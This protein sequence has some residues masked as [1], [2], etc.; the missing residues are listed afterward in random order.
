MQRAFALI[1]R[2][3]LN[4][5]GNLEPNDLFRQITPISTWAGRRCRGKKTVVVAYGRSESQATSNAIQLAHRITEE[6]ICRKMLA[7]EQDSSLAVFKY[8]NA[9]LILENLKKKW[10][11]SP[12]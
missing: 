12:K 1:K 4:F 7:V 5:A 9:L 11:F 3:G 8:F 10:G 2:S 6:E